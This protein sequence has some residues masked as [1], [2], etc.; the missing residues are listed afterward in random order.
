V[1][2]QP[3]AE[4]NLAPIGDLILC[5]HVLYYVAQ[6]EWLP[7]LKRLASWLAPQ[8]I[9]VFILQSRDCDCSQVL[10]HFQGQS[11]D[12]VPFGRELESVFS[13]RF[14]VKLERVPAQVRT[15][16]LSAAYTVAEFMLNLLPL[17][18]PVQRSELDEYLQSHF[19]VPGGGIHLSLDQ[20]FLLIRHHQGESP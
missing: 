20:D 5:S 4:V 14:Q 13:E 6:E 8:G 7:S 11:I 15:P 12:L 10:S 17:R 2:P 18:R 9:L 1:I 19:A 3:I 16:D